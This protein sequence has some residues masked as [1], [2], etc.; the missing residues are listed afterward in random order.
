VFQ[1]LRV[2]VNDPNIDNQAKP[3][4]IEMFIEFLGA[5]KLIAPQE[6][7][8]KSHSCRIGEATNDMCMS[9]PYNKVNLM[10]SWQYEVPRRYIRML[11]IVVEK[12]SHL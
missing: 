8:V 7:N 4:E 10:G 2:K 1:E 12:L 5:R 6:T 11:I 3:I 9:I